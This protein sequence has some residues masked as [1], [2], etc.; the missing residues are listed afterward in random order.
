MNEF[1][2]EHIQVRWAGRQVQDGCHGPLYSRSA[3][4]SFP[5]Y[6]APTSSTSGTTTSASVGSLALSFIRAATAAPP[7]AAADEKLA[8]PPALLA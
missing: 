3:R 5:E 2:L 7:A 6:D 4:A 1:V 8:L